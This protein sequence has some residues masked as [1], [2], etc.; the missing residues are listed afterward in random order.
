MNG[1]GD[2]RACAV[3]APL[4]AATSIHCKN[5]WKGFERCSS[6]ID[7][8]HGILKMENHT[9]LFCSARTKSR[10]PVPSA[11]PTMNL[12]RGRAKWELVSV[13]QG[14][15]DLLIFTSVPYIVDKKLLGRLRRLL[16]KS[17]AKVVLSSTWRYDPAGLFAAKYWGV[18][19]ARIR[20]FAQIR[21]GSVNFLNRDAPFVPASACRSTRRRCY[22]RQWNGEPSDRV[23]WC[24]YAC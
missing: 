19:G 10:A 1:S 15:C 13:I 11:A 18:S 8:F 9:T 5:G 22:Q 2:R 21:A 16:E 12:C 17:K 23:V 20:H 7:R 4:Q 14:Q 24:V 6:P 3:S